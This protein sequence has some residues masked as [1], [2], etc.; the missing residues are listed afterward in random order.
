MRPALVLSAV[1]HIALALIAM[2][3]L[4]RPD[5]RLA[6]V[7]EPVP[8]DIV[9]I[10]DLTNTKIDNK[11]KERPKPTP[12]P[13]QPKPQPAPPPPQAQEKPE[14]PP[15]MTTPEPPKMAEAPKP[16]VKPEIKP[17]PKK[18]EPK[19]EPKKVEP[20]KK[21][22][23]KKEPPKKEPPKKEPPKKEPPK[24]QKSFDSVLKNVAKLKEQ[25]TPREET[26]EEEKPEE[27]ASTLD[28]VRS[29]RLSI[30]EEDALR[31]Q[32]AGCWN[33]PVGAK[34][35]ENMNAEIRVFFDSSMR[36]TD[37][38]FVTGSGSMMDPHYRAFVESAIRAPLKPQC[39]VLNLPADKY[40]NKGTIIVNFSP[41]DML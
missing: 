2:F 17:E 22:P 19:P 16:E 7:P 12:K 14:P 38:K 27:T 40:G 39:N 36:V 30:S 3:G 37:V 1:L 11:P 13:A 41:R 21:E 18:V 5:T 25:T 35:V 33:V 32:L 31:R 29:D 6:L 26:K 28:E 20:P 15:P 24:E 34:G 8:V 9:T 23:P 4:P 10:G